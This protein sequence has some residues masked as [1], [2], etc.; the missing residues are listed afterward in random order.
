MH[1]HTVTQSDTATV[2]TAALKVPV[3]LVPQQQSEIRS[4]QQTEISRS[5]QQT[6][7]SQSSQYSTVMNEYIIPTLYDHLLTLGFSQF[8]DCF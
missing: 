2:P 5:R 7:T 6:E 3:T 4:R 8:S 1:V